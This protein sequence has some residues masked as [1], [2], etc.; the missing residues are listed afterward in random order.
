MTDDTHDDTMDVDAI[1]TDDGGEWT[2]WSA[3]ECA[4]ALS[5]SAKAFRQ[6]MRDYCR[7]TGAPTPGSGGRWDVDVPADDAERE[8]YFDALR[9]AFRSTGGKRAT[10][11]LQ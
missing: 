7:A 9:D 2:V 10:F 6:S 4:D 11:R 3:Q 8:A 5:M 1:V